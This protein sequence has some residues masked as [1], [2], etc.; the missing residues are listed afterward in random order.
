MPRPTALLPAAGGAMNRMSRFAG[1]SRGR[2]ALLHVLQR[3]EV[4]Y[5]AARCRV[6]PSAV[7][8]WRAGERRPSKRVRVALEVNYRIPRDS[9]GE[10]AIVNRA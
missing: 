9:W 7:Y 1:I 2:A 4:Q 5:V 6:S 10:R 8:M 3:T